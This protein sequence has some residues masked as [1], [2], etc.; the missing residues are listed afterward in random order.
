M[1]QG[2]FHKAI[3]QSGGIKP[4]DID[5]SENYLSNPLPWKNYSSKELFNQLL[6]LKQS[7]TNRTDA[8][9]I[10][11]GLSTEEI[12]D[13]LRSA[14]TVEIF[15]AYLQAKVSTNSMLRPFPDGHVLHEDGIIASLQQGI[16]PGV[17]IIFGTNRDENKLFLIG[18]PRFVRT[19]FGLP[20]SRDKELYEAIAKH[21]SNTW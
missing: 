2:L 3:S 4:G 11:K 6:I 14:S 20:R 10:Q 8:T 18:N 9:A 17:P 16:A 12:A 19:F 15:E 5:H 13:V 21:R 7:A 1:A